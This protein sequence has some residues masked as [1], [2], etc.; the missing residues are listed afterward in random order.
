MGLILAPIYIGALI[1]YIICLTQITKWLHNGDLNI[2]MTLFAILISLIILLGIGLSYYFKEKVYALS[3]LFR[4]PTW[5]FYIPGAIGFILIQSQNTQIEN[6][7]KSIILSIVF[8]GV[9][10]FIFHKYTFGILKFLKI[11]KY[12]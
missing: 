4:I 6:I 2:S 11:K 12:H 10:V 5:L 1:I 8:S 7:A 3:P 9:L